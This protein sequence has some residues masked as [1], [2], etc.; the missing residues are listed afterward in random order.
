MVQ[1]GLCFDCKKT[2]STSKKKRKRNIVLRHIDDGSSYR[3]IERRDGCSKTTA[4]K[5]VHEVGKS[6]KESSWIANFLKPN[7]RGVL[8]FDGT[9]ISV[10]NH[11]SDLERKERWRNDERFLNKLC[12]LISTDY[13]TR[14]LPH[15]SLGDN[16]NMIDLV[17]HFEQ[18]KKNGYP[19]QVLVRDGN[20]RI[21][22]AA[23]HVYK[24]SIPSQLCHYHFLNKFDKKLSEKNISRKERHS[25][26]VLKKTVIYIIRS[27]SIEVACKRANTFFSA[28]QQYRTSKTTN[29]LVDKFIRDF[30]R[31]TVYLQYPKGFVPTTVN[32]SENIN[33]QLKSRLSSMCGFQ[34]IVSAQSYL[35]LWCLK[36]R[37]QKFTDCKHPFKHLN[38]KAPLEIAG[39]SIKKLNFLDL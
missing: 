13:H 16:E 18:L 27:R 21:E 36:R 15:Y 10:R 22:T 23:R 5:Y 6:I 1:L 12:V 38:G 31:L 7:W 3:T 32:V 24:K 39:C 17:L 34:T 2:F 29:L 37:F 28:Q 11:F 9:Y 35:N 4:M 19:L 14:D 30:E 8:C 33:S 20:K 25:I 26:S